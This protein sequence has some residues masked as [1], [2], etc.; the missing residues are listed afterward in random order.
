[1][2]LIMGSRVFKKMYPGRPG[3]FFEILDFILNMAGHGTV[4]KI[5]FTG[6]CHLSNHPYKRTRFGV[7]ER[8]FDYLNQLVT[9]ANYTIEN[10]AG[11]L[12][13][14][15]DLY[16]KTT[17][18][19][20]VKRFFRKNVL[21]P[22][23]KSKVKI[24][25]IGGNHDSHKELTYGC[26]IEDLNM[27][28]D[29]TV[30]RLP[31]IKKYKF[32]GE[33]IG[34]STFPF[35]SPESVFDYMMNEKKTI[36]TSAMTVSPQTMTEY[37]GM[38]IPSHVK[39]L[40]GMDRKIMLGH[41]HVVGTMVT[42]LPASFSLKEIEFTRAM[43]QEQDIDLA[44]FGHIHAHQHLGDKIVIPGSI[45]RIDFGE[46]NDEKCFIDYDTGTGKWKPVKL[47]C[48]KMLQIDVDVSNVDTNPTEIVS[49]M[50]KDRDIK[51]AIVKV[52]ITTTRS[53]KK[54]IDQYQI[55]RVLVDAFHPIIEYKVI[56]DSHDPMIDL[57]G[58]DLDPESLLAAFVESKYGNKTTG[59][60][61]RLIDKS[62]S[63]MRGD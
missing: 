29:V 34:F 42:N 48:H 36:D 62:I 40:E 59:Y 33:K 4:M 17:I 38:I 14:A 60:K 43:I 3:D 24:L 6:D 20:N 9:I 12:A 63:Y 37:L 32:D 11:I 28:S 15:G 44:V 46:R 18:N 45:E 55:E 50:V 19:A 2:I 56:D 25:I 23:L 26:D 58:L 61:T 22:L 10:G 47:E 35:L 31:G 27:A 21:F 8:S 57:G 5:I 52:A 16:D 13:I 51:D 30:K 7:S 54:K 53:I 1:M 41:Y 39:A 49:S